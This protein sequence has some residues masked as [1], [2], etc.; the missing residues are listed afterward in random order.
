MYLTSILIGILA[1]SIILIHSQDN[2][3]GNS[4][5]VMLHI[6]YI[7]ANPYTGELYAFSKKGVNEINSGLYKSA[8]KGAT[9][10]NCNEVIP[11]NDFFSMAFDKETIYALAYKYDENYKNAYGGLYRSYDC[12]NWEHLREFD[13][14]QGML[15]RSNDQSTTIYVNDL[16]NLHVS[17]YERTWEKI[18]FPLASRPFV[19]F[20][21]LAVDPSNPAAIYFDMTK[22]NGYLGSE[23]QC[24]NENG[25]CD[26]SGIYASSDYGKTIKRILTTRNGFLLISANDA[27]VLYGVDLAANRNN[28]VGNNR[29]LK[30]IDGGA[31]W[32]VQGSLENIIIEKLFMNP[33]DHNILYAITID[34]R[35]LQGIDYTLIDESNIAD[36]Q[37]K[38][39]LLKSIDGGKRWQDISTKTLLNDEY[40]MDMAI[41]PFDPDVLYIGTSRLGI[42]KS[43]DAG[44][45][46]K[47][48][49]I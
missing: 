19:N 32:E 26:E 39:L 49:N 43:T 31:S 42:L 18:D 5:P 33:A 13:T 16:T 28:R 4:I 17:K 22:T 2:S 46:W 23:T 37:S 38:M 11:G 6:N 12:K 30:S 20:N 9:W 7:D 40:F 41:D 25:I 47:A 24:G 10:I 21:L 14:A 27:N 36:F 34:S 29:I 8:D 48:I 3:S 45:T 35:H 44:Q 15:I 1:V